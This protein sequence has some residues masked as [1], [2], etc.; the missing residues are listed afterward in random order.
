M[1]GLGDLPRW[2]GLPADALRSAAEAVARCNISSTSIDS[3]E[4]I[5]AAAV[6]AAAPAIRQAERT[7]VIAEFAA[8]RDRAVAAERERIKQLA[9]TIKATYPLYAD[10]GF[11]AEHLP[12]ADL[13]EGG[14][15]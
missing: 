13:L 12:F 14:A 15:P 10:P 6:E 2:Y 1:T 9:V 8:L 3:P 7:A 5:A 11:I 4:I